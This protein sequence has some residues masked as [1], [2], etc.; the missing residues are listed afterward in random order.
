MSNDTEKATCPDCDKEYDRLGSHWAR[1]KDCDYPVPV[2]DERETATTV[3][4]A[5][6]LRPRKGNSNE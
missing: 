2:A 1:S 5:T 3:T 4:S 6:H